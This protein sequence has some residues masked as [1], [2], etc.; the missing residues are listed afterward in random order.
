[1]NPIKQKRT[2]MLVDDDARFASLLKTALTGEGVDVV[3]APKAGDA[4]VEVGARKFDLIILDGELPDK[5]GMQWLEESRAKIEQ[6]PVMFISAS[7]RDTESHTRLI[8][9]LGVSSIVHKPVSL[10][11]LVDETMRL[12]HSDAKPVDSTDAALAELAVTYVSEM[13]GEFKRMRDI[14]Q[15]AVDEKIIAYNLEGLVNA[16]HKIHGTAGLFGFDEI[17][18]IAGQLEAE[19]R[20]TRETGRMPKELRAKMLNLLRRASDELKHAGVSSNA[21][22]ENMRSADKNHSRSIAAGVCRVVIVDDDTFFLKRMEHLLAGEGILLNSYSDSQHVLGAIDSFN[23]TLVVLDVNM[24]GLNGFEVCAELRKKHQVLPII[25]ISADSDD[26][27]REK[28]AAAGATLFE[29]KPIKNMQFI[30]TIK[31]LVQES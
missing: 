18:R 3:V 4:S 14:I 12:L 31:S 25:I 5:N 6:T 23:P 7:W 30:N 26:L 1:L 21:K 2:V 16:A 10:E 9:K 8:S 20:Q 28:A 15:Y 22:A 29:T 27:T 17:G 11:V 19:L 24:P 13:S